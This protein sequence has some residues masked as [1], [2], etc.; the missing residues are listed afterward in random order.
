SETRDLD[1]RTVVITTLADGAGILKALFDKRRL[2][3]RK[4]RLEAIGRVAAGVAHELRNPLGGIRLTL[5]ALLGGTPSE[6][7]LRRLEHISRA[8]EH[9]E[10]IVQDLLT[11]T[12]S[13]DLCR[14]THPAVELIDGAIEIAFA[15][16]A[17]GPPPILR[18]GP[19]GMELL[20]DRHAFTQV[21]V[22]LLT[23]ARQALD[24]AATAGDAAAREPRIGI[25]WGAREQCAWLEI[26]DMGPGIPQGEEERIFHPF[27]SLREGG[28]G[29]GL[30]IVQGRVEAHDGEIVVAR[31]AW[32]GGA[33]WPG[34]RSRI[35]LAPPQE[36]GREEGAGAHSAPRA[37]G[38]V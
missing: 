9:L 30:A 1:S 27:H 36:A 7:Q 19:A 18:E 17:A 37:K 28:T 5:D 13:G 2:R 24:G 16:G 23:N 12:R 33:G 31:D 26:A 34:A 11:F 10:H 14:R 21:L 6:R 20:V 15:D 22:N 25:W 3:E 4:K 35:L 29:L 38:A 8:V 32:G